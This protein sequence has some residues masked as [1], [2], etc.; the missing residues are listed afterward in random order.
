M[1]RTKIVGP[2]QGL[3]T[4]ID[5]CLALLVRPPSGPHAN[6]QRWSRRLLQYF[7]EERYIRFA[8]HTNAAQ[9]PGCFGLA[10]AIA[11]A[12]ERL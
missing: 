12:G 9:F 3:P 4:V 7:G 8:S 2:K 10:E 1:K 6:C 5:R 11:G